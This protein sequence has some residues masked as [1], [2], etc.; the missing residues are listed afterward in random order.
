[1]DHLFIDTLRLPARIGVYAREQ[2]LPQT[3]ELDVEIGLPEIALESA[4][5]AQTIDYARVV[6]AFRD[7]LAERHFPLLENLAE[8]LMRILLDDFGAPWA[9]LT[10]AKLG[11]L[12]GVRRVGI[13]IERGRG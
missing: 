9:R 6:A 1:M 11:V 3:L 12:S 8:H 2:V 10:I 4:Q 13:R 5:L 7:A